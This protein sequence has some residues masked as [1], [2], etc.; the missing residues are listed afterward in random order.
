MTD[1]FFSVKNSVDNQHNSIPLD[2]TQENNDM[3]FLKLE[4]L[5]SKYPELE[6]DLGWSKDEIV[7]FY[8]GKLLLGEQRSEDGKTVLHVSEE[9]LKR[10][11]EYHKSLEDLKREFENSNH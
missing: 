9:H 8:E 1:A 6:K 5:F 10:L 11:I 3:N 7:N 2:T 4:E